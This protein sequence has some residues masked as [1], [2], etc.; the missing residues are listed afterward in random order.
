MDDFR[1]GLNKPL[2]YILQ[3]ILNGIVTLQAV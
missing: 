2:S 3:S 1:N